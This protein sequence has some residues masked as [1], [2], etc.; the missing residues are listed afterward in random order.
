GRS[1]LVGAA[2]PTVVEQHHAAQIG[3]SRA[4]T[5]PI[6][7][8]GIDTVDEEKGVRTGRISVEFDMQS[9]AVLGDDPHLIH[10]EDYASSSDIAC[11]P[12]VF[13]RRLLTSRGTYCGAGPAL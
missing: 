3:Q 4:L 8:A 13:S 12:E 5:A 9:D 7:Q 1:Q 6:D 2:V 11:T 10:A